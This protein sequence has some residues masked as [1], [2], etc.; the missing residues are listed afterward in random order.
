MGRTVATFT[1]LIDLEIASWS[2]FR[3]CLRKEDQEVFDELFRAAKVHLAENFYAMRPVPF[4]SMV[5]SMLLEQL[6]RINELQRRIVELEQHLRHEKENNR[7][8][9]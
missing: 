6:K 4:D 9:L 7:L 3:R 5:M 2:K 8:A 1:N